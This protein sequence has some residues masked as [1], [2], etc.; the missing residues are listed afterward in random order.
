M[1]ARKPD[2]AQVAAALV[3]FALS[4]TLLHFGFYE[5]DQIVDTPVYESYGEAMADGEVPYRDF[6]VEYPPGALPVFLAPALAD[7]DYRSAFEWLMAL[8]G[9]GM[10]V[11]VALS[12]RQLGLGFGTLAFVALS[13]LAIGS[14]ILT[15]FDLW[16]AMLASFALAALLY[17]RL[18]LC[19][20]LLGASIAAKLYPAVFLPLTV[21]YVWRRRGRREALVCAALTVGVVVAVYVPFLLIAPGGVLSSIGRQLSRPLQIE[22]F[23]SA[24]L[25]A[26]H[27]A[28]GLGIEMH[29]SHGSQNLAGAAPDVLAVLLSVA[30]A[31]VLV[32]LW[33]R[34]ARER[35]PSRYELA[36]YAATVLTAFVALGKVLSPQFLI[37]LVPVVPLARR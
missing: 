26:A 27:D 15:R 23:G 3:L 1:T 33:T 30:Q 37:W 9:G 21:A 14:V 32:W 16:P 6:R 17:D 2:L 28:F 34:F 31:A 10:I 35:A 19:H 29:S 36:A 5:R 12:A 8:C 20:V 4:W 11:A 18:R 22:S 13:P 24:L 7:V 25:L